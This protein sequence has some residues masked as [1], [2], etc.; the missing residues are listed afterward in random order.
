VLS[1]WEQDSAAFKEMH[2]QKQQQLECVFYQ[3]EENTDGGIRDNHERFLDRCEDL[4]SGVS[5]ILV[6]EHVAVLLPILA[7]R[8]R[9]LRHALDQFPGR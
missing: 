9:I 8:L 5:L 1:Q 2:A 3:L 7:L 4:K 6:E